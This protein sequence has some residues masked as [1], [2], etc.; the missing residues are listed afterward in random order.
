M[1]AREPPMN[2]MLPSSIVSAPINDDSLGN[3]QLTDA[4]KHQEQAHLG[5][6]WVEARAIVQV[7]IHT[8]LVP[9][10]Q[11]RNYNL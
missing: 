4:N 11:D 5:S 6:C 3:A 2:V 8:N 10:M 7:S 9:T 1:H